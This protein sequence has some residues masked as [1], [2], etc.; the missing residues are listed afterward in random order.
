MKK[1]HLKG[2]DPLL[3]SFSLDE[4]KQNN[5][6]ITNEQIT[7]LEALEIGGEVALHTIPSDPNSAVNTYVRIPDAE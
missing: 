7:K 1:F 4:E 6:N 3:N 2:T 5:E